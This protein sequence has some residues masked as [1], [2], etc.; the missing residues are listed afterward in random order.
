VGAGD[1]QARA[2]ELIGKLGLEVLPGESGWWRLIT[3]SVVTVA[4]PGGRKLPASNTIHLVLSPERPVNRWHVLESDDVHVLVEGAPVEYVLLPPIGPPRRVVL[5]HDLDAGETPVV[6]AAAGVWT[7]LRLVDPSSY[8]WIVTTVTP[9][10]SPDRARIGLDT[11]V[12]DRVMGTAAWLTP[13]LVDDL[14]DER[15]RRSR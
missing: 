4:L 11:A 7:A 12:R 10:W 9:A 1:G 2:D 15:P 5:G 8:A 13:A 3:E 6:I 14:D